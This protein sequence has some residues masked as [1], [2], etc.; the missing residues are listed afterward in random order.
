MFNNFVK[1]IFRDLK[2]MKHSE[3]KAFNERSSRGNSMDD[4]CW[5]ITPQWKGKP[6]NHPGVSETN[7]IRRRWAVAG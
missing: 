1:E 4:I 3:L 6:V 7:V 2:R 5:E